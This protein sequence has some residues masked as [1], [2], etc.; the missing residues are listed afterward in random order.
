MLPPLGAA[1]EGG[2]DT[3]RAE[4]LA[5]RWEAVHAAADA[6]AEL[7]QLG[8]EGFDPAIAQFPARAS[9]LAG[10]RVAE[11][12]T[13]IEDLAF[14]M[15]TGLRALIVAAGTGAD[16]TPAALTLW[17]EFHGARAAILAVLEPDR[18]AA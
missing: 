4:L 1:P 14:V 6:V 5:A 3:A 9:Q 13:G 16:T 18:L 12:A 15:Q 2:A 17:R 11:I 7:A 8:H 10:W